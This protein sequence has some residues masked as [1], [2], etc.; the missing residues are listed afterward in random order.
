MIPDIYLALV[1]CAMAAPMDCRTEDHHID[2]PSVTACAMTA[3]M[4]I[5]QLLPAG[6]AL[7]SWSCHEGVRT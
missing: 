7:R 3:Q 6:Y 5:P 1:V 2:V 4:I